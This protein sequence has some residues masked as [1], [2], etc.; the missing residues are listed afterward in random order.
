MC[1]RASK[2]I[3]L[4]QEAFGSFKDHHCGQARKSVESYKGIK[5]SNKQIRSTAKIR[6]GFLWE[7][8]LIRCHP[9]LK[10]QPRA[11]TGQRS[12]ADSVQFKAITRTGILNR[13]KLNIFGLCSQVATHQKQLKDEQELGHPTERS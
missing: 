1:I 13:T 7:R 11:W 3:H 9:S 4:F 5:E 8:R 10:G 12:E 2:E 6:K